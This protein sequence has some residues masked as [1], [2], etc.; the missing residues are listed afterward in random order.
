M[1]KIVHTHSKKIA[2]CLAIVLIAATTV[3]L[4][5]K[6]ANK[7]N[8]QKETISQTAA[9]NTC[10]CY[11]EALANKYIITYTNQVPG[12]LL[13]INQ[14]KADCFAWQEFIAINW[15]VNTASSFGTPRDMGQVQW[16]TY[17]PRNILFPANGVSPPA[18]GTLVSDEY[19]KKFKTQKLLFNKQK[20][21]L[22]T[23]TSKVTENTSA[24][25]LSPNQAAPGG[26][27]WLGAQNNTNVWYEVLLNQDYY[28]FIVSKGYYNAKT[29]HDSVKAGTMI[30]FP[31]GVYNGAVGAIELKAAW[32]EVNNASSPKWN[33]YKLSVATVMDPITSALRTTTVALVGLHILHK[34]QTQPTWVWATFEQVDNVP[35]PN[36]AAPTYS[37]NFYNSAAVTKTLMVKS[38]SGKGDTMV[39]ITNSA[40]VSPP[41]YLKQANPVPIQCSRV[42]A[43][44]PI[45]AAPINALMQAN[46]SSLYP[47]S[48]WQYYQLVDVIWSN[49][50]QPARVQPDTIP[51][52]LN[53]SGM[54]PVSTIVANTTMETYVQNSLTCFNC[55][56]YA[57]IADYPAD[58]VNDNKI[59]DFSFAIGFAHHSPI[60][61]IIKGLK[62]RKTY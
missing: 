61:K 4:G 50:T 56:Q 47:N 6:S 46:I 45:N 40:N 1:K 28:N 55:H 21:K 36:V 12:D 35:A 17:M 18:W 62:S 34:T 10:T 22:L 31:A 48:V 24:S 9:A 8:A 53:L 14:S 30:N 13:S 58:T 42:N 11:A 15:P 27:N 19:A 23:F 16:E 51:R 44:D 29:Q 7:V 59:G 39:T 2:L 49:I 26:P 32:M 43:I 54:N 60:K 57:S 38:A 33:R 3:L 20:T 41:Y 5:G 37:Y 52:N 25:S